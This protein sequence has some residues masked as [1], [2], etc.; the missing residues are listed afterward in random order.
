MRKLVD[1]IRVGNNIF[2]IGS[3]Y[4][5]E[6]VSKL[7]N[8][9]QDTIDLDN[10]LDYELIANVPEK[11]SDFTNDLNFLTEHQSLSAYSTTEEVENKI[12]NATS[13][14]AKSTDIPTKVSELDNDKG[15]LTKH[16][17]LT[18]YAKKVDI[19]TKVSQ[20]ANDR[21]YTTMADVEAKGYLTEHQS[22]S[23]YATEEWVE[24]KGYLT[25][26][27]SLENY[28]TK[29]D[30]NTEISTRS[31]ADDALRERLNQVETTAKAQT[32]DITS[33]KSFIP[34]AATDTNKL[35]DK[36]WVNSS[37][38]SNTAT[39]R[40]TFETVADLP[41]TD[42]KKNDYAFIIAEDTSGDPE[43]QRYKYDGE[44]WV[45]EY[46][47]N[48]SS[49]TSDQWKAI[50]S[51]I[52]ADLVA[53]ITTNKD[54][55]AALNTSLSDEVERATTKETKL[56][57]EIA[58]KYTKPDDGIPASALTSA[59][60]TVLTNATTAYG[61]GN[62][63]KAGYIPF[64]QSYISDTKSWITTGYVKTRPGTLNLPEVCT[65]Q[66]RWGVLFFASENGA[67]GT[68]LYWPID[69]TYKGR[70]FTRTQANGTYSAWYLIAQTN[71]IPTKLS[72][73]TD[74]VVA[75]NYLLVSDL[76][77]KVSQF[78]NDAGYI[79]S[80]GSVT[81]AT[82]ADTADTATNATNDS[83]GNKIS[84][85]YATKSALEEAIE[86]AGKVDDV[87]VNG[88]SVVTD[89]VAKIDLSSYYTKDESYSNTEIDTKL[90][91][92]ANDKVTYKN[93]V[94]D[95]EV[96]TTDTVANWI[97]NLVSSVNSL[98]DKQSAGSEEIATI[99]SKIP[100][101]ATSTNQ[102]ADKDWVNSS[103]ASNTATFR[104]TFETVDDL[105]TDNVKD[106]DYAFII[107][108]DDSGNPEYQRY[109]Y[110]NG[111]WT[112]EYT[113]NNSSF[114]SDQWKAINSGIT[115][116]TLGT[117]INATAL[118][119]ELAKYLPLTGGTLTGLLNA[120]KVETGT[121]GD[122]YFQS[123]RFRGEGNASTYYHAI[124]FGY[125]GHNQVDF[126]EYGGVWNF[127]RNT[128]ADATSASSNLAASLQLGKLVERGN[129][130][131]YPGKSGTIA[132]TSDIPTVPTKLSEFT[133]D[134]VSGNYLPI[135]GTAVKATADA[136]GNVITDTYAT[137]AELR[138]VITD[139]EK[140]EEATA[141]ILCG[142]NERLD[143]LET[144]ITAISAISDDEI[145]TICV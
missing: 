69:G 91:D 40:G 62:H 111:A 70:M 72:E 59:V 34:E 43:Y 123:R 1:S 41:V 113:L 103:I 56:E 55:I 110:S 42:I 35:A 27:Q 96:E 135:D 119:D 104:G 20:L 28:S 17:S 126:Y 108:A 58:A 33:I 98:E 106:N 73:L 86:S 89:K 66:D 6:E 105:P 79:T 61:W 92:K 49:F 90:L 30:L 82:S 65:G 99:N 122:S 5:T 15:Y 101:A 38:A 78:T 84:A 31:D 95:K 2:G 140:V 88:T 125:A 48:N 80:S 19:P 68:Y 128:G 37:I 67:N 127:W 76:P 87:Q 129:T 25:E 18:E 57:N 145:N 100:A 16:Q 97:T 36:D 44:S 7:L 60:Q 52:T 85:T 14:L 29:E 141:G 3:T 136:S 132:L 22:L 11:L 115:S 45:F 75:G 138:E 13:G 81:H 74:D 9:K 134:V 112:F 46:T 121:G 144:S 114:T 143:V 26:H 120:P 142:I 12:N 24:S 39:F 71:D 53:Q 107:A 32:K 50:N 21:N 102:L 8:T 63:A 124:D 64:N 139:A 137:K 54:G 23:G 4:I 116:D 131:T 10:K 51:G 83:E 47:L 94:D 109:K 118:S 93:V 77:T 117:L 130:L 133:D